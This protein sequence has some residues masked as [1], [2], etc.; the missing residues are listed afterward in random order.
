MENNTDSQRTT[1]PI[2]FMWRGAVCGDTLAMDYVSPDGEEGYPGTLCVTICFTLSESGALAIGYTATTDAPTVL[3]LTN[4][5]YFNLAG[6]G[7]ALGHVVQIFADEYL[8]SNSDALATG[9]ISRV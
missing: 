7:S 3:N 2:T 5:S 8:K 1:A 4:H 6:G 9:E